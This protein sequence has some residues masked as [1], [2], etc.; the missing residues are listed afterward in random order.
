MRRGKCSGLGCRAEMLPGAVQSSPVAPWCGLRVV[1][2]D[3]SRLV[4]RTRRS[5][6]RVVT[7]NWFKW[8]YRGRGRPV[9]YGERPA[10]RDGWSAS[11]TDS[12]Y[13]TA[14][15]RYTS[16]GVPHHDEEKCPASR[17]ICK[18]FTLASAIKQ[19]F[20]VDRHQGVTTYNNA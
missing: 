10:P 15:Q 7:V 3:P 9:T 8:P 13:W 11:T 1:T 16:C 19:C 14:G 5:A 12:E 17:H 4:Q 6:M 18:S 20:T 2:F